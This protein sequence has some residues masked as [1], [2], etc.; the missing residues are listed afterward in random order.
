MAD[1]DDVSMRS[2]NE[3][4]N[5]ESS[6][7]REN[8]EWL[9]TARKKRSTAGNR[10]STLIQQAAAE[11]DELELLFAEDENDE[12]FEDI[13]TD[14]SDDQMDSSDDDED[15][16]PAAGTEEL[17]GEKELQAQERA[18][19]KAKKRKL[20]DGIPNV[21]RKRVKIDSTAPKAPPEPK[22]KT[23]RIWIPKA[24]EV[25]TRAST[26]RTTKLSKEQLQA[27]IRDRERRRLRQL[28]MMEKATKRKQAAKPKTMTQEERLAEAA[29]VEMKNAKSL[30]SWEEAEKIR[31]EEQRAK[32]AALNSRKL[33]GPVITWWSG[34]AEWVGGKLKRV[35]KTTIIEEKEKKERKEPGR[36]RKAD[37]V[38]DTAASVIVASYSTIATASS[39]FRSPYPPTTP[40]A[41]TGSERLS[42]SLVTSQNTPFAAPPSE[43]TALL[44]RTPIPVNTPVTSP[45]SA[46]IGA[47]EESGLPLR[48]A[49]GIAMASESSSPQNDAAT[50]LAAKR[51]VSAVAGTTQPIQ[52][53]ALES[54]T[55]NG[56]PVPTLTVSQ[57]G[58]ACAGQLPTIIPDAQIIS[59]QA[60]G[61]A[62]QTNVLNSSTAG[63][64]F[65]STP[66]N[67][68]QI[69]CSPAPPPRFDGSAPLP[70]F[71]THQFPQTMLFQ[72]VPFASAPRPALEPPH[73]V[74]HSTRNC[75]ILENFNELS[76]K[77]KDI[78]CQILFGRKFQKAPSMVI[79]SCLLLCP[80]R[81]NV[82]NECLEPHGP[83]PC[84]ITAYPAK[85][86][87]PS[88]GL[89]YLNA[90][91]YKEIQRL[92]RGDYCW[93]TLL[94]AYVGQSQYAARGVP[95]RFMQK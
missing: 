33:E 51:E 62:L 32:L 8:T 26:R 15:Q 61:S 12:V 54:A 67:A 42:E 78:Q 87:D 85:F 7:E 79:L 65:A 16:G 45:T 71:Y 56:S 90:Y 18:E 55:K 29:R 14:A 50:T 35:G 28:G 53:A 5:S 94:Q 82:A 38:E 10:L 77:S 49:D 30:N 36:K 23:E 58:N 11:D 83:I 52:S 72:T 74:E 89:Y 25:P 60:S 92:K 91:A 6:N 4:S 22:K 59:S 66:V 44:L 84:A 69:V 21:F 80:C 31:E 70:G 95:L 75:L 40:A 2:D 76:V 37:N 19:R 3:S 86:H 68:T 1:R 43:L 47:N 81:I 41:A 9:V 13:D 39:T 27:Q 63:S 57:A 17:D 88:T 20:N 93:S 34:V 73:V 64:S 46:P 24:K 48:L